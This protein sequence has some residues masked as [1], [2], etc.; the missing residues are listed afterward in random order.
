MSKSKI[1]LGA[2]CALGFA[3][4]VSHAAP[5][6]NVA[7]NVANVTPNA[8]NVTPN[9][10]IVNPNSVNIVNNSHGYVY[11]YTYTIL[12]PDGYIT[13]TYYL[14]YPPSYYYRPVVPR[15]YGYGRSNA[16]R[17]RR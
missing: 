11:P 2:L 9:A 12:T 10:R 13:R 5:N 16:R 1:I 8:A 15:S 4:G 3:G 14:P 7:P 17:Y 6:T